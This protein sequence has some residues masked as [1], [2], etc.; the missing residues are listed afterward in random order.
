MGA[1]DSLFVR[2][3]KSPM[4]DLPLLYQIGH[5]SCDFFNGDLRVGAVLIIKVD[6]IC[7]ETLQRIFSRLSYDLGT[8]IGNKGLVYLRTCHIKFYPEFCCN[9]HSVTAALQRFAY[10]S[11]VLVRVVLR[12]ADTFKSLPNVL[13]CIKNYSFSVCFSQKLTAPSSQPSATVPVPMPKPCPS[14]L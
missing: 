12:A 3:G 14:P 8:G 10:K 11:F 2:F 1:A 5:Y 4:S 13:Y 9:D 6:M 7:T